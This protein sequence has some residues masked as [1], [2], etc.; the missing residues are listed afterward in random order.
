MKIEL[1]NAI[2]QVL[3]QKRTEM[4]YGDIAEIIKTNYADYADENIEALK[5]KVSGVLTRDV[6]KTDG[7]FTRVPNGKKNKGKISYK[8]GVYCLKK[9]KVARPPIKPDSSQKKLVFSDSQ[10]YVKQ[11]SLFSGIPKTYRGKGGEYACASE[12][13]FRGY[14]INM[15]TVDDG[16]DIIA[17]K[18]N[19][20]FFIQV[21]TREWENNAISIQID[22]ESYKRY[23][24][25]NIYYIIVVRYVE[26]GKYVNQYIV[27]PSS[28]I[29]KCMRDGIINIDK[30]DKSR[31]YTI[32]VKQEC[33][34]IV[35][36]RGAK[37]ENITAY[38]NYFDCIK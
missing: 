9:Q 12:L 13:L 4:F 37:K 17:S 6:K 27:L 19:K 21:K 15:M 1:K 36:C 30:D 35:A 38:L 16:I 14:N 22:K 10:A 2:K 11:V 18:N 29:D 26:N 32:N 3:E 25:N 28:I 20:I 34:E 31:T 33:G 24:D 7:L 23:N 8:K 5:G